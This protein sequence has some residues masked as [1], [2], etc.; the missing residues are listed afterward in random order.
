MAF[1]TFA[2]VK[3]CP[4][5]NPSPPCP[6]AGET[7]LAK[8]INIEAMKVRVNFDIFIINHLGYKR[9]CSI[10]AVYLNAIIIIYQ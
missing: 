6:N 3:P 4:P 10:Q 2:I 7:T 5:S 8:P 9:N 1:R